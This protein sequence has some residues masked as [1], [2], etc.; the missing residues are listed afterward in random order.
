MPV[1]PSN[2]AFPASL[3]RPAALRPDDDPDDQPPRPAVPRWPMYL[4]GLLLAA[5][6]VFAASFTVAEFASAVVVDGRGATLAAVA[7]ADGGLPEVGNP[8]E[9][10]LPGKRA[11][12]ARVVS[13]RLI[14]TEAA[15]ADAGVPSSFPV[16][17]L[18]VLL[19]PDGDEGAGDLLTAPGASARI[20][21]SSTSLIGLIPAMWGGQ[22]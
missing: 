10:R 3:Y 13:A 19:M 7:P 9:I 1:D 14:G 2:V 20:E 22:R 5:D 16:P 6:L 21:I 4:V 18:L 12:D 11:V 15:R 8:A 17:V